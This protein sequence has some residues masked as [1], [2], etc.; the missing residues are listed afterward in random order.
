MLRILEAQF[1]GDLTDRPPRIEHPLLRHLEQLELDMLLSRAPR[2]ALDQVAE[3]VGREAK[4][5][6]AVFYRR[7]SFA[8]GAPSAK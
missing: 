5:S 4:L 6:G 3:I 8:A 1:V 2:L 7:K